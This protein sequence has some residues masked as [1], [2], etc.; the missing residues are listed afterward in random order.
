MPG[1]SEATS[2]YSASAIPSTMRAVVCYAPYD[3]RLE[4]VSVP[5]PGPAEILTKVEL[6]G[7]C[8]GDVKTFHGAP[9]LW[10]DAQQPQYVKPPVIPGHEFVGQGGC[11]GAG[12]GEAWR[13]GGR[14][15]HLGADRT[16][17]A[18]QV[19]HQRP[20]LDVREA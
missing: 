3:Y 14:S 5:K 8:M 18:M 11:A 2:T 19:L 20:L 6:C 10:G 7:I 15:R 16:L 17:L 9:S 4:V 13:G 12:H 1:V